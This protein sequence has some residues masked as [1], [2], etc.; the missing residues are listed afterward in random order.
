MKNFI[1]SPGMFFLLIIFLVFNSCKK[2]ASKKHVDKETVAKVNSWLNNQKPISQ[3]NKSANV[4]LLG[5]NLDFSNLRSE[6]LNN[7]EQFLIIPLKKNF[8]T[9]KNIDKNSIP[10]LVLILDRT[11][12]IRKGNIVLYIPE[13]NQSRKEVPDNAF[14]K[15]FNDKS[16]DGNGQFRFL[17]V[18]G[19]RLYQLDYKDGRLYSWGI[20]QSKTNGNNTVNGGTTTNSVTCID[21]YLVTTYYYPDGTTQQTSDYVGTTCYGC[22][23]E[24]IESFCPDGGTGG[25][26]ETNEPVG[27][28]QLSWVVKEAQNGWWYVS[29]AEEVSGMKTDPIGGGYFTSITHAGDQIVNVAFPGFGTWVKQA[30]T[31]GL[32]VSGGEARSEVTGKVTFANDPDVAVHKL[33]GW[34]FMIVFP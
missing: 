3:P 13:N 7:G 4:D 22:D 28:K 2:D 30:I 16:P 14:N 26:Q 5:N 23:N 31:V 19:R 9:I 34:L 10:E 25:N 32:F 24:E 12:S 6:E 29:S 8:Q 33:K 21:W 17:S 20:I 18:T 27:P 11:G 1:L 15:I